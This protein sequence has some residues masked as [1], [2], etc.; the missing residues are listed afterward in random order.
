MTS[1][2]RRGSIRQTGAPEARA[3]PAT[4]RNVGTCAH[5]GGMAGPVGTDRDPAVVRDQLS[6]AEATL[7]GDDLPDTAREWVEGIA[8]TLAWVVGEALESPTGRPVR[9]TRA[10]LVAELTAVGVPATDPRSP[11]HRHARGALRVVEW[12]LGYREDRPVRWTR[13]G[14]H[15][16]AS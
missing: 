6:R 16:R 1:R 8:D 11:A 10:E 14:T 7:R 15:A 9:A 4:Y 12:A 5:T 3:W 2:N 13:E